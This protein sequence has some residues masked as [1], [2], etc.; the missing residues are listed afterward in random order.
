MVAASANAARLDR[1]S[2]AWVRSD[3]AP[4]LSSPCAAVPFQGHALRAA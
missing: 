3:V 2:S 1:I 4:A